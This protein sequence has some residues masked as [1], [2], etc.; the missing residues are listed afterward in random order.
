MQ[1][2]HVAHQNRKQV[3]LQWLAL[4]LALGLAGGCTGKTPSPVPTALPLQETPAILSSSR[5]IL[6]EGRLVPGENVQLTFPV[7]GV[8]AEVLVKEGEG[9][10]K[11]EVIARLQGTSQV[12]AAIAEADV[13]VLQSKKDLKDLK[14]KH[15]QAL[16]YAEVTLAK[17]ETALKDAQ[18]NRASKD[19]QQA[20]NATLDWMRAN[21]LLAE[22]ALRKASEEYD[23]FKD[24]PDNDLDKAHV[25]SRLSAAQLERDRTLWVLNDALAKPDP[26][27]VAEA[28]ARVSLAAASLAR[29]ETDHEALLQGPNPDELALAEAA[30]ANAEAQ[31]EAARAH[32]D[33][34][35]IKAP[36]DGQ[37]IANDLEVGQWAYPAATVSMANFSSWKVE[38]IDL[39]ELDVTGISIGDA[40]E[41]TF[42]AI[43]GL[44][45][46]GKVERIQAFGIERQGDITYKA[47]ILLDKSDPRLLWNMTAFVTFLPEE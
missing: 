3:F 21:Y 26:Q 5:I 6:A 42:D 8:V 44:S 1:S 13:Q 43:P 24:R 36:F 18:E 22:D 46:T 29:A 16:A 35:Q 31:L 19:Y 41:V 33:D 45:M 9:V 20:S 25:L 23:L 2:I 14:E 12:E 34:L 38:T 37:V 4:V 10:K 39:T 7:S 15:Q 27:E 30:V 17:A 32:L 40:A 47:V 28:D 11:G